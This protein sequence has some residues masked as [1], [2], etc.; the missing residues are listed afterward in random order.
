VRQT[1]GNP[2]GCLLI[3]NEQLTKP[4][5]QPLKTMNAQITTPEEYDVVVLGSGEAGKFTVE[6]RPHET[7]NK[8][9]LGLPRIIRLKENAPELDYSSFYVTT[10]T[11][12]PAAL[13][14]RI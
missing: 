13:L 8:V 5:Q 1:K 4:I 9:R 2:G 12:T 10:G 11:G 3:V 7:E 14:R 6:G